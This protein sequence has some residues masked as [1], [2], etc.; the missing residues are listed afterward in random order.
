MAHPILVDLSKYIFRNDIYESAWVLPS[1]NCTSYIMVS[2]IGFWCSTPIES[3]SLYYAILIN[4]NSYG[5]SPPL[6]KVTSIFNYPYWV[7]RVGS[8]ASVVS[9]L[10][11]MRWNYSLNLSSSSTSCSQSSWLIGFLLGTNWGSL[12]QVAIF[13][14]NLWT[15]ICVHQ[16]NFL[17]LLPAVH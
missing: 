10:L 17:F 5:W 14:R 3:P 8:S 15:F 9:G 6:S 13:H 2:I 12:N 16:Q 11:K 1:K 7:S 4:L